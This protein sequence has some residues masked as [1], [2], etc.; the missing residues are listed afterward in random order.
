MTETTLIK[1]YD[2]EGHTL[3][4]LHSRIFDGNLTEH[5]AE[6]YQFLGAMQ[7]LL[8]CTKHVPPMGFVA[9]HTVM[10]LREEDA[11]LC[12]TEQDDRMFDHVYEIM[13]KWRSLGEI[14]DREK[15]KAI[16]IAYSEHGKE[17]FVGDLADYQNFVEGRMDDIGTGEEAE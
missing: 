5:Q 16:M 14:I 12:I 17:V 4:H 8:L 13:K 15:S 3:C 9:L 7:G 1:I 2:E 6:I 10:A 11:E